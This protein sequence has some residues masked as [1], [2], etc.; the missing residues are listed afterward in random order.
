MIIL[1]H[2]SRFEMVSFDSSARA[3]VLDSFR[4]LALKGFELL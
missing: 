4:E 3:A 1:K 2:Y